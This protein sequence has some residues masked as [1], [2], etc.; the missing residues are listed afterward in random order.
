MKIIKR[1]KNFLKRFT[2]ISSNLE[3]SSNNLA[4]ISAK[5]SPYIYEQI[6]SG[7]LT[8]PKYS[9]P[10]RLEPYRGTWCRAFRRAGAACLH[11]TSPICHTCYSDTGRIHQCARLGNRKRHHGDHRSPQ[12]PVDHH[13]HCT[14]FEYGR[15]L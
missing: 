1:I 3:Y 15:A 7:I 6:S 12:R 10:L 9:N 14:S 4:H 2:E 13:H 8:D 11:R 5:L